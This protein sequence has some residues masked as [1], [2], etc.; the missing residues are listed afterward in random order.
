MRNQNIKQQILGDLLFNMKITKA[1]CLG[2]AEREFD[3]SMMSI[4]RDEEYNPVFRECVKETLSG[5]LEARAQDSTF[6]KMFRYTLT[7][8]NADSVVEKG[9]DLVKLSELEETDP[10]LYNSFY[11]EIKG[12]YGDE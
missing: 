1:L 9:L 2:R 3:E 8:E 4:E 5:F 7:E 12:K 11:E 6:H 10:K